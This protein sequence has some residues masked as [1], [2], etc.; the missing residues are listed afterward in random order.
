[1]ETGKEKGREEVEKDRMDGENRTD[2]HRTV[3]IVKCKKGGECE[4]A[5]RTVA[6]CMYCKYSKIY[7]I[8]EIDASPVNFENSKELERIAT[9]LEKIAR[10]LA[11]KRLNG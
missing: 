7:E 9:A 10:F 1:M 4:K 5:W 6:T 2:K 11:E 8:D 3:Y